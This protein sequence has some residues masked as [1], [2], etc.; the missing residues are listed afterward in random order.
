[1]G[2]DYYSTFSPMASLT[3]VRVLCSLALKNKQPLR[4]IDIPQ[5]FIQSRI[6]ATSFLKLPSGV[7][8]ER[9]GRKY[10]VVKLVKALYGLKQSPQLWNKM[11]SDFLVTNCGFTRGLSETSMFYKHVDGKHS[12]LLTEVDDLVYTGHPDLIREFE[13]KLKTNWDINQKSHFW[14]A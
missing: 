8:V 11:L 5:A 7:F 13:H 14:A 4:H 12:I 2:V 10:S 1:M 6:D 9:N 3:A